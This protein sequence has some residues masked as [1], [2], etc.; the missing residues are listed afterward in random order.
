MTYPS[1]KILKIL[2]V[3]QTTI[4]GGA[5]R[6]AVTLHQALCASGHA[7]W[8]LAGKTN[9]SDK[10]VLQFPDEV[11][12]F[13]ASVIE[14]ASVLASKMNIRVGKKTLS[15]YLYKLRDPRRLLDDVFG[16]EDFNYPASRKVL[17]LAPDDP[18]IVHLH[19]LHDRYFD[20]NYL[21]A[22]SSQKPT[23]I[24]LHDTWL[25]SGHC[26]Y[27]ID[28]ERWKAG[29][30]YCP[31][32]DSY[33]SVK[34]DNTHFNW[35]R[36][37]AIFSRS[38]LYIATPSRW[39]LDEMEN[40]ILK[41][42]VIEGRVIHNGIDQSIFHPG[43]QR[44][45]RQKLN[46]PEDRTVLLFVASFG[47]DNPY[48]DFDTIWKTIQKIKDENFS[49]EILLLVLGQID[50]FSEKEEQYTKNIHVRYV[51]YHSNSE[52]VAVY[53][54][55][56]DIFLQASR[57]DTFPNVVLEALACGTPVIATG[58]GG[59]PEQIIDGQTGYLVNSGDSTA[60]AELTLKLIRDE[61]L[62]S[63][64]GKNAHEDAQKRFMIEHMVNRYISWYFEILDKTASQAGSHD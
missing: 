1:P 3:N 54:R 48:K 44:E 64:M 37:K 33:P 35:K 19:N 39:I 12:F 24:T 6:I 31:H 61:K 2:Q 9:N 60:M 62:R 26:A 29:C 25:L 56:A 55:A 16:L 4:Q 57:A 30:G 18:D 40:S 43:D 51:P 20:L 36:K 32:L 14:K 41:S 50:G 45:A 63:T 7:S 38:K 15:H 46:I 17:G 49:K 52:D 34:F 11:D 8:L 47:K 21:P 13:A 5:A 59:I 42:A 58:V 53:Y 27:S 10:T 28:C 23:V 22:L